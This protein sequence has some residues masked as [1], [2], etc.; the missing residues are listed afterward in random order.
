[1]KQMLEYAPKLTKPRHGNLGELSQFTHLNSL[2]QENS[3]GAEKK[4]D[5][6]AHSPLLMN[7]NYTMNLT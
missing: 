1:M 2:S 3:Y 4:Q 6:F 5:L 7:Q